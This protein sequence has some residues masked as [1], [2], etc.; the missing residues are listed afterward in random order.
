MT[1]KTF[2]ADMWMCFAVLG[3]IVGGLFPFYLMF[4]I[5]LWL[6]K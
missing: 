5:V 4:E 2:L 3:A 1:I 6:L